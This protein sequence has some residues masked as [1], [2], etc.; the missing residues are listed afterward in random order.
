M[1]KKQTAPFSLVWTEGFCIFVHVTTKHIQININGLTQV[2]QCIAA[3]CRTWDSALCGFF[4][5]GTESSA[6]WQR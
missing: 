5:H 1:K 6:L 2:Y 4:P 3:L